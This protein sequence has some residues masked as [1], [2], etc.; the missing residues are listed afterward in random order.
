MGSSK[1][2]GLLLGMPETKSQFLGE[3]KRSI[4]LRPASF[5]AVFGLYNSVLTNVLLLIPQ[6]KKV[7]NKL[8]RKI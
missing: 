2:L 1:N 8:H 6:N 5:S 4:M 7:K 3:D